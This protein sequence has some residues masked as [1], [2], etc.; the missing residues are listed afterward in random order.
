MKLSEEQSTPLNKALIFDIQDFSVQDGPGIRTTVFF[1]GCP[2]NCIWCSNPEGQHPYPE[3]MHFESLCKKSHRCITACPYNAVKT[4]ED[5]T[6]VFSRD[7]CVE[8]ID[9]NCVST[10]Y[11]NALRIAGEYKTVDDILEKIKP[12][13][14]FYKNSGGG[15]TLSGGEPLNQSGFIHNLLLECKN[16]NIPVGLETC[17]YFSWE[18]IISNIDLFEFI[19]FDLKS[20]DNEIHIKTTGQ[21]N[22]LIL[23]NLK[24]LSAICPEK[25]T[26]SI[27]LIPGVNDSE[28]SI[29]SI[30]AFCKQLGL[31]KIRLL[32]YHSYGAGKYS[33]LGL[34]YLYESKDEIQSEHL[35]HLKNIISNEG[36][37]CRIE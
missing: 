7:L 20:L 23:D 30:T 37:D 12:N 2:L 31:S 21:S 33:S 36:I 26:I 8:C 3:L 28:E 18:S 27:P 14:P 1:K 34:K 32:P 24:K 5:G 22:D 4:N 6:P 35:T 15:I 25:I 17:G 16:L 9:K 10:C 13:I 19:Y 11:Q 29:I